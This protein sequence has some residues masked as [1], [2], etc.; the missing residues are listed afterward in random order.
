MYVKRKGKKGKKGCNGN[1]E[2]FF[3]SYDFL[4]AFYTQIEP[5]LTYAAE[6]CGLEVVGQIE[7]VQTFVI[8]RFLGI[9]LHSSNKLL[10]G[11]TGR[12]PTVY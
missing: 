11:E 2:E 3:R 5:I 1:S 6:L 8:K 9:P 4:E 12:L 7:K 10:Y